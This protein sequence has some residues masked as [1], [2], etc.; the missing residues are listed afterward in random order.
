MSIKPRKTR[1][2]NIELD[3]SIEN[4]FLTGTVERNTPAW[5]LHVSRFFDDGERRQIAWLEHR[6]FLLRK[7][8]LENRLGLP[9]AAKEFDK[10]LFSHLCH[11]P[12]VV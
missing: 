7:W 4:Y 9:W 6:G 3:E 1:K 10:K 2:R 5:D 8:K 12:G 11:G